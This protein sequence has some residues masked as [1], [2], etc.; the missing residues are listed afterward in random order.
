MYLFNTSRN[1][2]QIGDYSFKIL[3]VN[4]LIGG[5]LSTSRDVIVKMIITRNGI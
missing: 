5:G 4:P 2:I 3:E 1:P